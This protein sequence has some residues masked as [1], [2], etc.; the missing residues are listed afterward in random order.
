M[1][2]A[3]IALLRPGNSFGLSADDIAASV[4]RR[5]LSGKLDVGTTLPTIRALAG[6]LDVA[7]GT[8]SRAYQTL[9]RDGFIRKPRF[10]RDRYIVV[11]NDE[12]VT[13]ARN[14]ALRSMI[15]RFVSDV[16]D[17]G[18]TKDELRSAWEE[19]WTKR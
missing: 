13:K 8:V 4:R 19:Q 12:L 15:R 18:F 16:C 6:G 7:P 1:Q 17:K 9:V 2:D 5:I 10:S 14:Q 11:M 3:L